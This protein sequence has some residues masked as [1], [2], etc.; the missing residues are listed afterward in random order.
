M[1]ATGPFPPNPAEIVL[2]PELKAFLTY[3]TRSYDR[4]IFDCPPLMAVSESGI[5]CSLV[6]GVVFVV[7]AGQTS[8]KL[9][10]LSVQI[11]RERGAN[12]LGCVLNNLEFGRVCYY[13]YS[14]YYGYYDYDYHYDNKES[15]KAK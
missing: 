14:T 1:I 5:L 4:V 9:A 6:D 7:W 3:A 15:P 11:L 8:R 10:K 2:R 12:L 13:Y